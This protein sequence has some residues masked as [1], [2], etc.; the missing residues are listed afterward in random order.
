MTSKR[1]AHSVALGAGREFDAIRLLLERWGVRAT[2]IGD[3]AAVLDL[4][5]GDSLVASVDAAVEGIHFERDWLTPREIG[6]RAVAAALS[7]LA[8]MAARPVGVLIALGLPDDW[9]NDLEGIGDGIGDAVDYA[10]TRI[11]GGN[12]SVTRLLS[13][14]TTV[15]GS[16]YAPLRRDALRAGDTLY[17]TGRLGGPRAAIRELRAG[18]VATPVYRER[19]ARPRPRLREALWLADRGATSAID[20]SDGLVA[21]LGHLTAASGKLSIEVELSR[22]PRIDALEPLDAAASGEEYELIVGAPQTI[23]TQL[24]ERTFG[25][26]LTAIGTAGASG[27]GVMLHLNGERV[28]NPGGYDHLSL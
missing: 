2:G 3:D 13:I 22:L 18:R 12:I 17:V 9:H 24:F 19:F 7:D 23:D 16:V 10:G 1:D 5:R 8:A 28:A 25:L 6:Y 26:T 11:A 20:I 21:D 4:P 14:T 15:L 27:D